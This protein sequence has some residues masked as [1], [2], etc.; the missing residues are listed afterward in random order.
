MRMTTDE[1]EPFL[2]HLRALPFVKGA[3]IRR[4]ERGL[5]GFTLDALL[6][7]DTPRQRHEFLVEIKRTNLTRP[8]VNGLVAQM[9]EI[10]DR[11]WILF[12]PYIGRPLGEHLA[13][14]D[15]NYVDAAGNCHLRITD[16]HFAFI[17]GKKRHR[18]KGLGR[19]I[20]VAGYKALFAILAR[21]ELLN[22]PVRVLARE[23]NIGKTAAAET[24]ERLVKEGLVGVGINERQVLDH[25]TLVDRW[26]TG[27]ATVVRPRLLIG[28][29][30]TP[31]DTP[32]T[33]EHRIQATLGTDNRW[34]WGGEAA[35][36]RLVG[37]YRGETTTLH[38]EQWT[39]AHTKRLRALPTQNGPL[40]ILLAPSKVAFDGVAPHTAHPLLV[41]T[42]L[43]TLGNARAREAAAEIHAEYL[44][45]RNDAAL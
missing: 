40:T 23:A 25:R 42:E 13:T 36:M 16:E 12:V 45:V 41:Y 39:D 22:A 4:T 38:A 31:D 21:P 44:Q 34:A 8:L 3:E 43:L 28:N 33:L 15:V 19:G 35:A 29:F 27:Y 2:D 20:G 32:T 5:E 10:A 18:R 9:A 1:L 17:Q 24:V 26:L 30:Q 7:L 11:P 37:H 14:Q 6:Y